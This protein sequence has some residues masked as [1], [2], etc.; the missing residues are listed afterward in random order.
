MKSSVLLF[1]FPSDKIVRQVY[2]SMFTVLFF[3]KDPKFNGIEAT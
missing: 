1:D 2:V 3:L